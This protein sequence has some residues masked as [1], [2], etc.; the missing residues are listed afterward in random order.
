MS[1]QALMILNLSDESFS[2]GGQLSSGHLF[3][4]RLQELKKLG[5]FAYDIGAQSTAPNRTRLI[6]AQEESRRFLSVFEQALGLSNESGENLW[7]GVRFLSLDTFRPTT[8]I[9]MFKW[10][11][12][13]G[14]KGPIAFNDVS[15]C[16]SDGVS[17]VVDTLGEKFFYVLCHNRV[18]SREET[19]LHMNY[20][21]PCHSVDILDEVQL[22]FHEGTKFLQNFLPQAQLI[23]DPCLGFAKSYQENWTILNNIERLQGSA[24][25]LL[26]ISRKSFL[27]QKVRETIPGIS[28]IEAMGLSEFYHYEFIRKWKTE[29][30][31]NLWVRLHDPHLGLLALGRSH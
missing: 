11:R 19:P 31:G 27:R 9:K 24:S 16:Y 8:F 10:L 22:F 21:R 12:A 13:N 18:P 25:L 30:Q 15:G 1:A 5:L 4:K 23:F 6:N 3:A 20:K 7:T 26:G 2:D 29:F 17:E 28:E 14:Y